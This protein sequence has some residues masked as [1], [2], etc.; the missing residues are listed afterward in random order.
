[1]IVLRRTGTIFAKAGFGG[2]ARGALVGDDGLGGEVGAWGMGPSAW[3][4][5]VAR[6]VNRFKLP[7]VRWLEKAGKQKGV[8]DRGAHY[9]PFLAARFFGRRAGNG[10]RASGNSR[11]GEPGRP[12]GRQN[13]TK[14]VVF[15]GGQSYINRQA[16]RL[17]G[18]CIAQAG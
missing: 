11:I 8:S 16:T 14:K 13:R 7:D 3:S 5:F 15:G 2:S 10:R 4:A 18:W 9:W 1:M 12:A 17:A 6:R